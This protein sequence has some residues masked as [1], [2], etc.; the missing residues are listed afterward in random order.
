ML[1]VNRI[2]HFTMAERYHYELEIIGYWLLML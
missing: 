2:K 1:N